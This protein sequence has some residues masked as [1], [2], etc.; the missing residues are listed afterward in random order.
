[1]TTKNNFRNDFLRETV[2]SDTEARIQTLIDGKFHS[3]F[4][5]R[6]D[7]VHYLVRQREAL[8]ATLA[9]IATASELP[10]VTEES[11]DCPSCGEFVEWR[12]DY[13]PDIGDCVACDE[14]VAERLSNVRRILRE[15]APKE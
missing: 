9:A 7:D 10:E 2:D 6:H 15:S 4:T 5:V 8:R 14:C 11:T 13:E 12:N 3:R 1:M